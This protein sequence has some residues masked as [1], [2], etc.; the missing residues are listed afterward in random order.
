M[1]ARQ[2]GHM[3]DVKPSTTI[4]VDSRIDGGHAAAAMGNDV[5]D[6]PEEAVDAVLAWLR[7]LDVHD[8]ELIPFCVVFVFDIT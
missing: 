7:R 1:R 6:V 3:H 2:R 8:S 4:G 5:Y